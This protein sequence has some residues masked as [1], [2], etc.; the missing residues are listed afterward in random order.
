MQ[1]L[2][3][4][5]KESNQDFEFYPTTKEMVDIVFRDIREKKKDYRGSFDNFSLLDIGAG[6][7][8]VFN[9]IEELMPPPPDQYYKPHIDKYAIE[10]S[11]ILINQMASDIIVIGTDFYQ[12][13]FVDKKMDFIFCNPPYSDYDGWMSKILQEANCKTAYFVIPQRWKDNKELMKS[14]EK[15]SKNYNVL[16]SSD[17]LNAERQARAKIDIVR[18]DFNREYNAFEE[19]FDTHFKI[20]AEKHNGYEYR[21]EQKKREA[22]REQALVKGK[23]I[24]ESLVELYQEELTKLLNN[25]K[26]LE[27]LD[28]D[29]LKELNINL[30]NL[31]EGLRTKIE[32]LKNLYWKEL[33]DNLDK[34]T[35]RLTSGSRDKLLSV[36]NR[37]TNIDFSASNIYSVVIWALKNANNYI[38]EQLKELYFEMSEKDNIKNY[39]SNKKL[40]EDGWRYSKKE[41]THYT[42]DYRLVFQRGTCFSSDSWRYDYPKGLHKTT[43]AFLNDIITVADNLGFIGVDSS[44]KFQWVAGVENIFKYA[45]GKEFMRVRAFKNGNIHCKINQEFMK[46]FNIEAARLNKWVKDVSECAEELEIPE[47]EVRELYA[48]NKK[49]E[50]KNIKLLV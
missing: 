37:N 32:G 19:W 45:D 15:R 29:I 14:I 6:N 17:F 10:K 26:S 4:K 21:S 42:L 23:N 48:S 18:I 49:I 31:K 50:T 1:Q 11:E 46:K 9:L 30:S 27:N 28:S 20:N 12:Q 3:T 44:Y 36:L 43:H 8:N 13:T 16:H 22:V 47:N 40:V 33:F 39:K 2:I 34:I 41:Q 35:K 38:D 24:I 5:L 25:Y 7:G